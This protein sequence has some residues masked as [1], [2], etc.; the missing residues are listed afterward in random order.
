MDESSDTRIK[1]EID[2][3]ASRIEQTIRKV[4]PYF[5]EA[6]ESD[7]AEDSGTNGTAGN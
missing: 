2:E 1:A 5:R 4:R 3:I 7:G 6:D